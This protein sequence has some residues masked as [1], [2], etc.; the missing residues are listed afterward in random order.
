MTAHSF[1]RDDATLAT[2]A[3][4]DLPGLTLSGIPSFTQTDFVAGI[5]KV[6]L[7]QDYRIVERL[8][9]AVTITSI[10]GKTSAGSLQTAVKINSTTVGGLTITT[11]SSS[12]TLVTAS[13]ANTA[14]NGD[15]IV[16][17]ASAVTSPTDFSF[18]LQF[19]RTL[20]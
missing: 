6:P 1:L 8:P 2:I 20:A 19:T 11:V 15:V 13:S 7:N 14:S 3:T 4:G 16:I 17:T 12:Q 9:F 18:T 5:V 10:A